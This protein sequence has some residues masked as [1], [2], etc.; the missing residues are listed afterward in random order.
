[1]GHGADRERR[2]HAD[3]GG[4]R[5]AAGHQTTASA[6]SL[7]VANDTTAPIVTVP[8]DTTAPTVTVTSPA[9]SS[10]RRHGDRTATAADDTGVAGV[11]FL[12]DG[13]PLGAED[14]TAPYEAPGTA[15][16]ANGEHT[17]RPRWRAMPRATTASAVSVTVANDLTVPTVPVTSPGAAFLLDGGSSVN[18]PSRR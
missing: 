15:S 7:T 2:A 17:R 16:I 3:R 10:V 11:R 14:T 9:A 12:L 8:D 18:S 4:A 6:V 5:D 13:E 1:M